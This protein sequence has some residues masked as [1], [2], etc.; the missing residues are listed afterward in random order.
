MD[1]HPATYPSQCF[2]ILRNLFYCTM[3]YLEHKH[4]PM[5]LQRTE[6]HGKHDM[7]TGNDNQKNLTQFQICWTT[8]FKESGS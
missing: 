7:Y 1:T 6:A 5:D 8:D 4:E 2:V 3:L